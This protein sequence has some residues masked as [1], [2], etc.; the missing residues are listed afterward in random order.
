VPRPR[1]RARH[2]EPGRTQIGAQDISRAVAKL[3]AQAESLRNETRKFV[4]QM[5]AA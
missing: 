4:E 3:N 5:R 2:N 1:S